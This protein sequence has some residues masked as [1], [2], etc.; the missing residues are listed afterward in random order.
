V[1]AV[2]GAVEGRHRAMR[3]AASLLAAILIA[4]LIKVIFMTHDQCEI[5]IILCPELGCS[6][7]KPEK[8]GVA[9]HAVSMRHPCQLVN[10]SVA[11]C[12]LRSKVEPCRWPRHRVG[13]FAFTAARHAGDNMRACLSRIGAPAPRTERVPSGEEVDRSTCH[14]PQH[15]SQAAA[16][17]TGRGTCHRPQHA[18]CKRLSLRECRP[19]RVRPSRAHATP[20]A[21]SAPAPAAPAAMWP[22]K[23]AR[24]RSCRHT[25]PRNR[26]GTWAAAASVS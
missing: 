25:A 1:V 26:P 5:F 19:W 22:R 15:L 9:L 12:G 14:R 21:R 7:S 2:V 18:L 11:Q 6:H 16:L 13:P 8:F 24:S 20:P 3:E 10:M 4:Y 17:V 23:T